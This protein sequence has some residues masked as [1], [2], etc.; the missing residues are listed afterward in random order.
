MG[1]IFLIFGKNVKTRRKD[2]NLSQEQL[3]E[4]IDRDPRTIRL[5]EAGD[6]NPTTKTIYKLTKALSTNASTLLGF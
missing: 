2:L 6:S 5:I 1:N 4:L 3:A